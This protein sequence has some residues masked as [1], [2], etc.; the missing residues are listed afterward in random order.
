MSLT[1]AILL[2]VGVTAGVGTGTVALITGQ[3][4]FSQLQAA[5]DQDLK[6]IETS[7]TALQE[8]LA[9]LSEMV[10]QNKRGLDLLLLE[11]GGLCAALK[12]ECCFYTDHSGIVKDS[13]TQLRERI[14]NR[15]K[16]GFP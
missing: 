10:L 14:K 1:L 2:G 6:A 11:K 5:I 15:E 12:E 4:H 16:Q 13:M 3:Q 9:S 7:I 8:S